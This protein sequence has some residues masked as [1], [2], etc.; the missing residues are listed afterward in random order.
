MNR[1]PALHKT[2][3]MPT[4]TTPP[5]QAALFRV[6]FMIY[7]GDSVVIKITKQQT[8]EN[9]AMSNISFHQR[10]QSGLHNGISANL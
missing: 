5:F 10:F 1:K 4:E 7:M 8:I 9:P 6:W 2:G 3:K